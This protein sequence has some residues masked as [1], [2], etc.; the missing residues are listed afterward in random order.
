MLKGMQ[1]HYTKGFL[2]SV[3]KFEW[4]SYT[5]LLAHYSATTGSIFRTCGPIHSQY[6]NTHKNKDGETYTKETTETPEQFKDIIN[7]LFNLKMDGV[8]IEI[9]GTFIWLTGNTKPYKDDIKALEFRYSPKKYAWY[10][11]PSDYKKRSRKNY[12]MDTIRGMY[13]SQKVKEDKEEKKYLQAN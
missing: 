4:F 2:Y 8:S 11:A 6:S 3:I 5:Q 9:V 7:Q 12:D 1:H 13:G 10:K